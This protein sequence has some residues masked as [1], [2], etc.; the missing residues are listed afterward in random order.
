[1]ISRANPVHSRMAI[2]EQ[3]NIKSRAHACSATGAAFS[4]GDIFYTALF[5][6]TDDAL[7]RRDYSAAA[8]DGPESPA[9]TAFSYWRSVYCPPAREEKKV[10]LQKESAEDLLRRLVADDEAHTENARFILAVMLERQKILRQTDAHKI[11]ETKLLIYEHR[12]SGDVLLIRDPEIPL[13]DVEKVQAEVMLLLD[14]EHPPAAAAEPA[15]QVDLVLETEVLAG[16]PEPST[17]EN[18][19][20]EAADPAPSGA[21]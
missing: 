10:A 7:E 12:K 17:P 13:S 14:Q 11:G 1:M 3:W 16:A 15:A 19:A 4:D 8:W 18:T 21:A 20:A 6:T 5:E 9:G 2:N